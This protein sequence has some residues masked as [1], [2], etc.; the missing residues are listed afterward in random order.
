MKRASGEMQAIINEFY[1]F[2]WRFIKFYFFIRKTQLGLLVLLSTY[3]FLEERAKLI[4]RQPV[5]QGLVRAKFAIC[6]KSIVKE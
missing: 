2:G 6:Y 5:G 3:L 1:S 4:Q